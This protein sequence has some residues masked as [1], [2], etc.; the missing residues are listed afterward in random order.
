LV[1]AA[2]G[3]TD[4]TLDDWSLLR[5]HDGSFSARIPA[6]EFSLDL[7][8]EPTQPV[9]PQGENGFSRKGPLPTDASYYFSLPHLAVSGSVGRQGRTSAVSG[10]AWLD[11]E[12]SS[13][14]LDPQAI[15]WD[16]LGANLQD[17][18]ALT[19]FQIR[20]GDNHP[21][22]SGGSWRG[23]DGKIVNLAPREVSFATL[24][25][26]HSPHSGADYPVQRQVTIRLAEGDKRFTVTPL[27]DDQEL[28]S[29]PAGPVYWEGAVTLRGAAPGRGYL[30]LTGYLEK[31]TL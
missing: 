19:A 10:E 6:G 25:S 21:L 14:M 12:W 13:S 26:W 2:Q 3:N 29:R 15:G 23:K 24:R 16:W 17:G 31:L 9:L 1:E 27:F 18:A 20:D 22:W 11:R 8:L 28:D 7:K 30:E 5:D 4:I